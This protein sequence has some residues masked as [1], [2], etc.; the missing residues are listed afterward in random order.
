MICRTVLVLSVLLLAACAPL[1]PVAPVPPPTG[2]ITGQVIWGDETVPG[3]VVELHA[4]DWRTNPH[5]LVLA[6]AADGTGAYTLADV[7]PGEYEVVPAWP[8]D[9]GVVPAQAA[10]IPMTVIGGQTQPGVDLSLA[11]ALTMLEPADAA[12]TGPSPTL[13]WEPVEGATLYRVIV[14]NPETLEG[15]FGEDVT[16]TSVTVAPPL[17]PGSYHWVVNALTPSMGLLAVG[18]GQFTVEE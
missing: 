3:A 16:E 10:G 4:P 14:N 1:A 11:T 2:T 12:T 15:F 8:E 18:D 9:A 17:L 7:P 6:G 13:A 5:S